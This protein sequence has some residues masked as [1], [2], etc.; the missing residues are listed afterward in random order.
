MAGSTKSEMRNPKQPEAKC[1]RFKDD[2]IGFVLWIAEH[3]ADDP[4]AIKSAVRCVRSKDVVCRHC[5]RPGAVSTEKMV[6]NG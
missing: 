4:A 6:G 5:G 3:Y 1:P 2:P